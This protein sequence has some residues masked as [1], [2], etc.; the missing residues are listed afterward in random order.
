MT[1]ITFIAHFHP[2][3]VHLPIGMLLA[4]LL[5]QALA[6]KERY[7]ALRPAVPVVLLAGVVF[8]VLSCL[9]G[10]LLSL[11]GDY[12]PDLVSWHMWMALSLTA[13]SVFIYF[14]LVRKGFDR[15]HTL[16]SLALLVLLLITGH[17]GGSL[18]HGADYLSGPLTGGADAHAPGVAVD[19][20]IANVQEAMAYQQVIRP[21]FQNNCYTCHGHTRQKGGLRVDGMEALMKGGKDG[22]AIVSHHADSSLLIRRLLLPLDDEHHMP[23][24]DRR[25]LNE[26]QL[27]LL[28]WWVD[29]GP[30][31]THKIKEL[32]QPDSIRPA[33][34]ALQRPMHRPIDFPDI[35]P[36]PVEPADAKA[37]AALTAKGVLVLPVAQKSN[38][39]EADLSAWTAGGPSLIPLLIP[40]KKQL[41]SLRAPGSP[42][43][44]SDFT[45][46]SQCAE[47]RSLDLAG[48]NITDRGLQALRPLK[49]LH[50]LNLVGT[51][52][53]AA[54]V[55]S[56]QPLQKLR[57]LYLFRTHVTSADWPLIRKTFPLT[58]L[59]SGGYSM[60]VLASDTQ[61]VKAPPP[62]R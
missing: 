49:N 17:L 56:L 32:P 27:T 54:G 55:T 3:L 43:A 41:V 62:A 13:L 48:T 35:P 7:S 28:R 61:V 25:Q 58:T 22:A 60:P 42:L 36:T 8:A 16:L 30:D 21:I 53:T 10:W 24:R 47:L 23:P 6:M 46:I 1:A 20:P 19:T 37:I 26:R 57:S 5:L 14:R 59:D 18:T 15:I 9:T 38:W 34:L 52:V 50:V 33:L 39:L 40:L 2:V 11:S 31:Y 4:A 29:E 12:D 45:A 44:D 51:S